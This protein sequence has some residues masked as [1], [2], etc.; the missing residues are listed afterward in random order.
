MTVKAKADPYGMP[1]EKDNDKGNDKTGRLS[2]C[3][4]THRGETAMDG[5]PDRLWLG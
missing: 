2:S 3:I 5:A 1:N 4:P